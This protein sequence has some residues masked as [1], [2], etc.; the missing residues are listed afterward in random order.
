MKE[1]FCKARAEAVLLCVNLVK[2]AK[3]LCLIFP[4]AE[5]IS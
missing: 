4:Q 5:F 1:F 3:R 2:S